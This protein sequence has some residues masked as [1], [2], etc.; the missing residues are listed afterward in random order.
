[1]A[2]SI[3]EVARMSGVTARTL[4]HYHEIGLLIPASIGT[5]GYRF[6]DEDELLRLQQILVLRSLGLGLPEIRAIVDRHTD[7]VVALREHHERLITERDRLDTV[8]ASVTRTIAELRHNQEMGSMRKINDPENLFAGFD[9]ESYRDEA[10]RRYGEHWENAG[11]QRLIESSSPEEL[12]RMQ[13]EATAALVRM[14]G[15]MEAGTPVDDP[16]VL[17]ELDAHYAQMSRFWTPS[18]EEYARFGAMQAEDERF[19]AEYERVATGLA[20]YMRDAM[21]A[22]AA[23]RLS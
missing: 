4:R 10:A 8:I 23:A 20:D 16:A 18:A 5:N 1:M 19:R 15:L 9:A 12:E 22:Y 6:Y 7:P 14:A 17:T 2:W 13:R 3:A 21:A 11:Q